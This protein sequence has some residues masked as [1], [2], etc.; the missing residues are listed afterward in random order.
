M[1]LVRDRYPS[2][3]LHYINSHAKVAEKFLQIARMLSILAKN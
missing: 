1:A 2:L 3:L